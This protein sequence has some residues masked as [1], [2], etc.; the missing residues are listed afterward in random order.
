VGIERV[1]L[2]AGVAE[3]VGEPGS[4]TSGEAVVCTVRLRVCG[5]NG[6]GEDIRESVGELAGGA[7]GGKLQA[8]TAETRPRRRI[9][10]RRI[11]GRF[12][13]SL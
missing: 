1:A 12:F 7:R 2:T 6:F 9:K 8:N 5:G 13:I 4:S 10:N 3:G 11:R